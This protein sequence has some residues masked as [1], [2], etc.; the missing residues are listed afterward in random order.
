MEIICG[1][2]VSLVLKL[3]DIL[4]YLIDRHHIGSSSLSAFQDKHDQMRPAPKISIKGTVIK[5]LTTNYY[6]RRL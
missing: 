4:N 1:S 3:F 2:T 6:R 5:C